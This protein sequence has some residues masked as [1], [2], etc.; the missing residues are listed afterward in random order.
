[1]QDVGNKR[2]VSKFLDLGDDCI[3]PKEAD[4]KRMLADKENFEIWRL[5]HMIGDGLRGQLP[6]HRVDFN[7]VERVV[8]ELSVEQDTAPCATERK[9]IG[10]MQSIQNYISSYVLVGFGSFAALAVVAV[11]LLHND[12]LIMGSHDST[13][14]VA[15]I[16]ED[17]NR[18][19]KVQ[20]GGSNIDDLSDEYTRI[21]AH[22]ED[23]SK[24]LDRSFEH[25]V[26]ASNLGIEDQAVQARITTL[27]Q[28]RGSARSSVAS[29]SDW[30][31][32]QHNE[33]VRVA[34][35]RHDLPY[36]REVSLQ[37]R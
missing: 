13:I 27:P 36:A 4:I 7:F 9:R 22:I 28:T 12:F 10:F 29:W 26:V 11:L 15:G 8:T 6:H 5:Y 20:V 21:M 24:N 23:G 16:Q 14:N 33:I 32:S 31:Y 34:Y 35:V 1:M 25:Q 2:L 19:N 17:A 3:Y 18:E 30:Y 37:A